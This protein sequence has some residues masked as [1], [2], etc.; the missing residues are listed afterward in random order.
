MIVVALCLV[1]PFVLAAAAISFALYK[2]GK[3]G[4]LHE[5]L[6]SLRSLP[7]PKNSIFRIIQPHLLSLQEVAKQGWA[8]PLAIV[9]LMIGVRPTCSMVL[10]LWPPA[11][12]CYNLIVPNFLNCPQLLLPGNEKLRSLVPLTMWVVSRANQCA[13]CAA[14]CCTFAL[15]RG[16]DASVLRDAMDSVLSGKDGNKKSTLTP[17]EYAVARVAYGLGTVPACL[18]PQDCHALAEYLSPSEIEWIVAATAMFGSFN[19]YMDGLALPLERSS[20][21]ETRDYTDEAYSIDERVAAALPKEETAVPRPPVDDWTVPLTMIYHGVRP[22]GALALDGRLQDGVPTSSQDCIDYLLNLTGAKFTV[23]S[24]LR[25]DRLRRA[26]TAVLGKNLVSDHI[27]LLVKASAGKTYAKLV[28]ENSQ[29]YNEMNAMEQHCEAQPKEQE[30]VLSEQDE[31]LLLRA[32]EALSYS[33]SR[34]TSDLV[35][36]VEASSNITASHMVEMV[37]FLAALQALHRVEIYYQEAS[38]EDTDTILTQ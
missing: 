27:S 25:H 30:Q 33:P 4:P 18:K 1:G 9:Q 31:Q 28:L 10:H 14:H 5:D 11:Y 35:D 19:K 24:E 13:Y 16:V 36:A 3:D 12:E 38:K 15:R 7:L 26:L 2:Q 29:L 8:A 34:M 20:Y 37:S 32:A 21:A 17:T 6:E 23:I 22:G